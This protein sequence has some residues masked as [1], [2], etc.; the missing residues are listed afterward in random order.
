[1][2]KRIEEEHQEA[3]SGIESAKQ[4]AEMAR[5]SPRMR[6]RGFLKE[7]KSL[8]HDFCTRTENTHKKA[9]VN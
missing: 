1:M 9:S 7:I 5:K 6:Y 3:I 4:Y 2:L 8:N